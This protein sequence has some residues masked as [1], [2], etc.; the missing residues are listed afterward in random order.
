MTGDRH[1]SSDA[2]L[3]RI[4]QQ[5][6]PDGGVD[7]PSLAWPTCKI[8]GGKD[9]LYWKFVS[10]SRWQHSHDAPQQRSRSVP[11]QPMTTNR[12]SSGRGAV[13]GDEAESAGDV[14]RASHW[15]REAYRRQ[16]H[17]EEGQGGKVDRS[18][19]HVKK[20]TSTQCSP[21]PASSPDQLGTARHGLVAGRRRGPLRWAVARHPRPDLHGAF[22]SLRASGSIHLRSSAAH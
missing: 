16:G 5:C 21:A 7:F 4:Q 13:S 2:N 18:I 10:F 11:T 15:A 3:V 6:F 12:K 22:T 1:A 20:S 8:A 14:G 17:A 9:P 19:V